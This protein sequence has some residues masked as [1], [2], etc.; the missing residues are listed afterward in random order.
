MS[1]FHCVSNLIRLYGSCCYCRHLL[2]FEVAAWQAVALTSWRSQTVSSK[3]RIELRFTPLSDITIRLAGW[4]GAEEAD[5]DERVEIFFF[6]FAAGGK[7]REWNE[8]PSC[9]CLPLEVREITAL[10]FWHRQDLPP[11]AFLSSASLC[12]IPRLQ[13]KTDTTCGADDLSCV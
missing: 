4:A 11:S 9:F 12:F 8:V 13:T 2:S 6:F 3:R 5:E 10:W 1:R 7:Q